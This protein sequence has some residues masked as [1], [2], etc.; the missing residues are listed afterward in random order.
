MKFKFFLLLAIIATIFG[1]STPTNIEAPQDEE[2]YTASYV[3]ANQSQ[4][5]FSTNYRIVVHDNI[6]EPDA[7]IEIFKPDYLGITKLPTQEEMTGKVIRLELRDRLF[8]DEKGEIWISIY[9]IHDA[10]TKEEYSNSQLRELELEIVE[11]R[12]IFLFTH[13]K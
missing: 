1:C 12:N 8:E 6:N 13:Y 2:Y 4:A 3:V 9:I 5:E 11:K 7:K 10:F